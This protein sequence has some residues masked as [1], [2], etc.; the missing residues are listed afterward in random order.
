MPSKFPYLKA[1]V[2]FPLLAQIIGTLV[3]IYVDDNTDELFTIA[4]VVLFSFLATF[5]VA[6]VPALLIALW[7][8]IYRYTRYNVVAI[9]LISLTIAFCYGNIASFIY[10]TLTQPAMTFGVWLHGGGIDM[11]FLLS[12]GMALYSVLV[13]PLL[14]PKTR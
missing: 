1:L 12:F 13:L 2:L 5:I 3:S 9:V 11:A 7:A 10:M 6:T 14:L 4:D 8:K